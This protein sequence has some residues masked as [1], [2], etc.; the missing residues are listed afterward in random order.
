[1]ASCTHI[2]YLV[3]Y[4]KTYVL[5]LI[6]RSNLPIVVF[7]AKNMIGKNLDALGITT[8]MLLVC[9]GKRTFVHETTAKRQ[10]EKQWHADMY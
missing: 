3:Q 9:T 2:H 8:N 6:R 1:M 10:K 7:V 5:L 4:K